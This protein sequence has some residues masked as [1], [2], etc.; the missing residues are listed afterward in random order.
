MKPGSLTTHTIERIASVSSLLIL[1]AAWVLGGL[2]IADQQ[3]QQLASLLPPSTTLEETATDRFALFNQDGH[4]SGWLTL[5][6]GNG[7]GGSTTLASQISMDGRI[8]Q[9]AVLSIKDTRSY[10]DKVVDAKLLQP[11]LGQPLSNPPSIDAISGATIT[12]NALLHAIA[13]AHANAEAALNGQPVPSLPSAHFALGWVNLL[14]IT[15]FAA[16]IAINRSRHRHKNRWQWALML[17]AL[18][19]LG[20]SSAAL[21]SS[22]TLGMLLAADWIKGLGSYTPMLLL[23]LTLGYLLCFNRNLYCQ[24]LCPFGTAQQCLGKVGNAKAATPKHSLFRWIPRLLLLTALSLG[25]YY[26]NPAGFSY[27]PFAILFGFTGSLA[28]FALTVLVLLTSLMVHRPWCKTL[29]PIGPLTEYLMFN[30]NWLRKTL[31]HRRRPRRRI[32]SRTL[33]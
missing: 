25:L 2:R 24:S 32:A 21:F 18:F 27:E 12:S 31:N 10:V 22:S 7:Y 28:L 29:C 17:T 30:K 26:R 15:L 11:L 13:T 33:E 14:A 16:A 3:Q 5:G 23:I 4:Q 1:L 19:G 9:L 6:R 20:F 8:Q